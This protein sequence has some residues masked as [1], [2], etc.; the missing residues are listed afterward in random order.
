MQVTP[1]RQRI[2]D[3]AMELA[4]E[5][6]YEALHV[7]TIAQR[8]SVSS[9]TIYENFPSL[10][11]LLILAVAEQAGE[12]LYR[13]LTEKP[14]K[15]GTAAARVQ[16]VIGQATEVMTSNRKLTMAFLRALLCGKPDV[17]QHVK[18]FA[19][20]M[21]AILTAAIAPEGPDV[22]DEYAANLLERIWFSALIGW[23]TGVDADDHIKTVMRRATQ[24][25]LTT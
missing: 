3:A 1:P 23:A 13:Q 6:G 24:R 5:G 22:A 9:R 17:A 18:G 14:R 11:S 7:R 10:D 25:I 21:E 20:V 8:A 19:E 2:L 12:L 16:K 4:A 15:G